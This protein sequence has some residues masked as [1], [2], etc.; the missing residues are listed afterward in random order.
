MI[1]SGS[2]TSG[3]IDASEL[4]PGDVI[5][6]YNGSG[7]NYHTA[8]YAGNGQMVDCS[9]GNSPAIKVHPYDPSGYRIA[10][11][12]TGDAG[13]GAARGTSTA[14]ELGQFTPQSEPVTLRTISRET[15][16]RTAL[17]CSSGYG[18]AQSFAGIDGKYAVAFTNADADTAQGIVRL[19]RPDGKY[20]SQTAADIWHANGS[21]I[22]SD[23]TVLVAGSLRDGRRNTAAELSVEGNDINVRSDRSLPGSASSIAYDKD[24]RKYILASGSNMTVYDSEFKRLTTINRSMHGTYYQDIGA[25]GGCIFACHTEI[26][27]GENN[28]R[29]YIDIYDEDTGDYY[30]TFFVDYGELESADI[31]DGELVLLIHIKGSSDN[32][33]QYTGI[34]IQGAGAVTSLI[35]FRVSATKYGIGSRWQ[36]SKNGITAGHLSGGLQADAV[37][38]DGRFSI[39]GRL[40]GGRMQIKGSAADGKIE[41]SGWVE[42]ALE[43]N[44]INEG[45]AEGRATYVGVDDTD[46]DHSAAVLSQL[47][48]WNNSHNPFYYGYGGYCE[49]WVADIYKAAGRPISG[50]CCAYTHGVNNAHRT[51]KIP[52]GALIFSG[53][54][55]NGS[56]YEN[57]HRQSAYCDVCD[58]W[59]GHV[60]IYVGNGLV[61]GSQVPYLMSVDTWIDMFGYGGWSLQ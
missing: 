57:G 11:R 59:A 27:G 37:I 48:K 52:K 18:V 56:M 13:G 45:S 61:A 31:V 22:S 19:F 10:M 25:G 17:S 50:A 15:G 29:N 40:L 41:G 51:G 55:R 21:C 58:H 16:T 6:C 35:N 14:A 28:G 44:D 4:L 54:K 32:Y 39:D 1:F 9:S 47:T 42:K 46:T 60:A 12:Y 34:T 33:I 5:L 26:K 2:L 38:D 7:Y 24:T 36:L 20:L 30:G 8:M 23:N 49:L 43:A 3:G 53:M